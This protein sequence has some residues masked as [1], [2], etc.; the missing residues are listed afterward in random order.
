METTH[1]FL[2]N[3]TAIKSMLLVA[4][5]GGTLSGAYFVNEEV[6]EN[7]Q[8][9]TRVDEYSVYAENNE[10]SLA[11]IENDLSAI[12]LHAG[13]VSAVP[14]ELMSLKADERI[15][16]EIVVID[17]LMEQN[18]SKVHN[19]SASLRTKDRDVQRLKHSV[20]NLEQE[21]EEY[22]KRGN[23]YAAECQSVKMDLID[24]QEEE[25]GLKRELQIKK[26]VLDS[27]SKMIGIQSSE[28]A[29]RATKMRTAYFVV[30][31]YKELNQRHVAERK[32]GFL[33]IGGTKAVKEDFER[34]VF[35]EI[36]IYRYT[37]IPVFGSDAG[38]LT[39][40][41]SDSYEL[42]KDE[43]GNVQWIKVI[44]PEGFWENSKYLVVMIKEP[45][46]AQQTIP[47]ELK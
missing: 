24:A 27:K 42:V 46:R 40:H 8:L 23:L 35:N 6:K 33:G 4:V 43:Q 25:I 7:Q 17:K 3:A 9:E 22:K 44:D 31:T 30:G 45:L 13:L 20:A 16:S 47:V 1:L 38:F 34:N 5:A 2:K 18:K 19:L 36:D 11:V 14:S 39:N 15:R 41:N 29:Q 37:A 32:G 10:R 28:L 26:A 21:M 12:R